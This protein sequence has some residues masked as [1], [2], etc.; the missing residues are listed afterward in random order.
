MG[1]EVC[2]ILTSRGTGQ[3]RSSPLA[4]SRFS[5]VFQCQLDKS[6]PILDLQAQGSRICLQSLQGPSHNEDCHL[7]APSQEQ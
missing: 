7:A 1:A 3:P 5:P 6:V 2:L 4:T